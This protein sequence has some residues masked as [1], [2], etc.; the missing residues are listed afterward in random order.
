MKVMMMMVKYHLLMLM[1]LVKMM[2]MM[3]MEKK[4]MIT[5]EMVVSIEMNEWG[6]WRQREKR[7]VKVKSFLVVLLPLVDDNFASQKVGGA[8]NT[9]HKFFSMFISFG[10]L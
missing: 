8:E 4:M 9:S 5:F 7:L 3:M 1:L 10:G 6:E 2:M